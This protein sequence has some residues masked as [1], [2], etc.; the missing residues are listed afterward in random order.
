MDSVALMNRTDTKYQVSIENAVSVLNQLAAEYQVLEIDGQRKFQYRTVYFDT[1]DKRLLYEHLRGKLNREK[2]RAREY[3]G[4][5]IRFFELKKKTNKG[6][7]IKSRIRKTTALEVIQPEETAFLASRSSLN[8]ADLKPVIDVLFDRITLVS[9]EYK[10]RVTIDFGLTFKLDGETK[11]IDELAIIEVKR[12]GDSAP[13]TPVLQTLKE[14][15]AYPSS[16]SK[17]CLGM[18]LLDDSGKYNN[19]KPKLLKLNKLSTD[20]NIW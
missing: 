11:S 10:E 6:R 5:D 12:D 3:V 16:L 9:L 13:H 17:Y 4:S 18:I 2:V 8:T 20:G 14:S 15:S 1:D 19:Y 7:T